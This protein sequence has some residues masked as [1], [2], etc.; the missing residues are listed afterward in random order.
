MR[1]VIDLQGAQTESRLRG[2]GRYS[3]AL[4]TAIVRHR[5][6]H[7]VLI[8]LNG[9]YPE[10][11]EPIRA[12]F[13]GLLPEQSI[14]IW[15]A[16]GPVSALDPANNW[17][18]SAAEIIR[19]EFLQSLHPDIVHVSSPLE[20]IHD[21]AIYSVGRFAQ[22]MLTAATFYDAIPLIQKKIYLDHSPMLTSA[23]LEKLEHLKRAE[24]L[25]AISE[26]ARMEAIQHLGCPQQQ[27]VNIGA[28][29][30]A[31]F[32]VVP[33][34]AATKEKLGLKFGFRDDF[35]M[36]SSAAD[37]RKN[38]LRLIEAFS[39]LPQELR[40]R[41]PLLIV[42]GMPATH[43]ARF[44]AHAQS[45][46]LS[47]SD[48]ILTGRINDEELVALYNLCTLFVLPSWHEGFGLPALEAM[49]CGAPT[50]GS[51]TSS[52]PEVIGR[53]DA[54]F[55]PYS[56]QA[57]MR[58]IAQVLGDPALREE[59]AQHGL[60]QA[61]K[62][63]W[64]KSAMHAVDA[65]ERLVGQQNTASFNAAHD[66]PDN[67]IASVVSGI[68][69]ASTATWRDEDLLRVAQAVSFNIRPI[70]SK[71]LF[72]DI[73]TI[74]HTDAKSGIQ[75]V[76]RSLL[77][78]LLRNQPPGVTVVPI[79]FEA[80][81]FRR[82]EVIPAGK[83]DEDAR[84]TA[85]PA[86][87]DFGQG[88][89][90]LALDLNAHLSEATHGILLRMQQLGMALYF[91]V[92][93]I[94]VIHRPDWWAGEMNV[95]FE[96]WLRNIAQAATGLICISATVADDVT[97]WLAANPPDRLYGPIVQSFHLG[98]DI[99]NSRP[100]LGLPPAASTIL[101]SIGSSASFLMV[102]TIEPRKGHAQAIAAFELLWRQGI[103][104]S[105]VIVGK[106]GWL[107]DELHEK[108]LAHP[109][110]GRKFHLLTSVSDEY[111]DKIYTA[112]SCLLV[113]SEG[114]GFGLPLIEAAMKG[115]PIIARDLPVF[116]EIAGGHAYYFHGLSASELSESIQ[117]WFALHQAGNEPPSTGLQWLTWEQS[118]MQ[119]QAAILDSP[120]VAPSPFQVA[121]TRPL[122]SQ[123]QT[124]KGMSDAET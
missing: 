105:L 46:G 109:E 88:D 54:L 6:D 102:G 31:Q 48:V 37:E 92:Y 86:V 15:S 116:R 117:S 97:Q 108:L 100:S 70:N 107:V 114:E 84:Y 58:K 71:T 63:S 36:Y 33:I 93:D 51:N 22:R 20:G 65:F 43:R 106:K 76:V 85:T 103:D 120:V 38:H 52:I 118:A 74:V 73:S 80:G 9:L 64:D 4:A 104:V 98:A 16:P 77:D 39:L 47:T 56:A 10:T 91:I 57:M 75:R 8:A 50:I 45:F 101:E 28:A 90:Y 121:F 44:L 82:A 110:L 25:L 11:I 78:E 67:R 122:G 79:Y 49:S 124:V 60:V 19:E 123:L 81:H 95:V 5:R 26:S 1:I 14:R 68:A 62:F 27:V 18:R 2:I 41:Y 89:I 83:S 72:L 112:C 7:E 29:T 35:L 59:L 99:Q 40:E 21:D 66:H 115:K 34:D 87:I 23:Y 69:H 24:L 111:L 113:P 17:R 53:D 3:I 13:Q 32:Q 30:D 42:G 94:L 96:Q 55:D 12:A 119:L 61:T